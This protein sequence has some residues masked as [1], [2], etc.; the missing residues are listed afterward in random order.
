[1]KKLG[2][3]ILIIF[4]ASYLNAQSLLI[5]GDTIVYGDP[6][7]EIVSYLTVKNISAQLLNVICEKNV[8]SQGWG[9]DN[10]FCWGGTCLTS[11]TIISPDFTTIAANSSSTEFQGHFTGNVGSTATIEYCFYPENDPADES[12]IIINYGGSTSTSTTIK[13]NTILISEFYPNPAKE[14]VCFDYYLNKPAKLVVMD[15]LGN[16]VKRI[17]LSERGTQKINISDLSKG[18]YFGN[19][20]VNNETIAIKKLIVR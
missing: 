13:K 19:V 18:I 10:F 6:T 1:M 8:I 16:E 2:F 9:G 14:I 5:T 20:V 12:C 7:V 11:S 17:R 3:F 4:Q 15:I